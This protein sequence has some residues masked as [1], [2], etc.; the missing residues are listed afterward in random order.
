MSILLFQHRLQPEATKSPSIHILHKRTD[1]K[2]SSLEHSGD[3]LLCHTSNATSRADGRDY[4]KEEVEQGV[5]AS[6]AVCVQGEN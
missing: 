1:G 3:C 2:I 4:S 5:W 6:V